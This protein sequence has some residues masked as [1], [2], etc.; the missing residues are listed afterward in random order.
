MNPETK[1]DLLICKLVQLTVD[2]SLAWTEVKGNYDYPV[3]FRLVL[4]IGEITLILRPGDYKCIRI[5]C[6]NGDTSEDYDSP[7]LDTL[8]RTVREFLYTPWG[9]QKIV[10]GILFEG[11]LDEDS[12]RVDDTV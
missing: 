2:N 5:V 8:I 1:I 12:E 6:D 11:A 3:A 9:V 10:D 7:Y 4:A